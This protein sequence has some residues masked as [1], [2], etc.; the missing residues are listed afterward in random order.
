VT[1][2]PATD[3]FLMGRELAQNIP[4]GVTHA[5][6]LAALGVTC[7][8][9]TN[10][11]LN[12][13][14]PYG[15]CSLVRMAN[16]YANVAQVAATAELETCLALI[17]SSPARLMRVSDYGI[18]PGNSADMIVLDAGSAAEAVAAIAQ[19]LFGL[20]AGRLTFERPSPLLH[21]PG[22][23]GEPARAARPTR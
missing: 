5:H 13:F 9:S 10:N 12:P 19:P 2:L 17:T 18:A 22:R 20:K 14:T 15:D 11:V 8:V 16:L 21:A 1:V 7:S 4:R 3:L 6:R 23:A